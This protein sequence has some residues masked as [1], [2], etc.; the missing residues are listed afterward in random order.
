MSLSRTTLP[1]ISF[2]G[3][4]GGLAPG[5]ESLPAIETRLI[6]VDKGD[7]ALGD[8]SR[9]YPYHTVA[10][11]L[12]AAAALGPTAASRAVVFVYPGEYAES[13]LTSVAH[14]SLV[15]VGGR[16]AVR[17]EGSAG[18][19]LT[20][21]HGSFEV[22]NL[23]LAQSVNDNV[24]RI[25]SPTLC[26]FHNCV[27]DFM[28]GSDTRR[29]ASTV[30]G[31]K[32][33]YEDCAWVNAQFD[34]S[35]VFVSALSALDDH[36]FYRC[37]VRGQLNIQG[38]NAVVDGCVI[39]GMV[40]RGGGVASTMLVKDCVITASV[41]WAVFLTSSTAA[42]IVNNRLTAAAGQYDVASAVA[43]AGHVIEGNVMTRG[44]SGYVSHIAPTRNVGAAGMKDW[45]PTVQAALDSCTFDD[46]V[47]RL[48]VDVGLA[49]ALTPPANRVLTIDGVG[50]HRIT[51][52]AATVLTLTLAGQKVT[53]RDIEVRGQLLINTA[54][55]GCT[56]T[57]EDSWVLGRITINNGL[58]DTV[59]RIVRSEVYGGDGL[60]RALEQIPTA[61]FTYI[62]WSRLKGQ[63]DAAGYAILWNTLTNN[64]VYAKYSK[65]YHGLGA[66][67]DPMGRTGAQTPTWHSHHDQFNS[68][69]GSGWLTNL[70]PPGQTMDSVDPN[71]D[72]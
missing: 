18:V 2:G 48:L 20:V 43:T 19:V 4:G 29:I 67:N 62:E 15:G 40:S 58:A 10:A 21:T 52:A 42:T 17:I 9:Q 41:Y 6:F 71:A 37:T 33:Q 7:N 45:Y 55:A 30:A 72:Y 60:L 22:W 69:P 49:A 44:I 27:F 23:T 31:G 38:G 3:A 25:A 12:A 36:R 34:F 11:G 61:P 59:L 53:L 24:V 35:Q 47:V 54:S 51:W 5:V 65:F 57:I 32:S 64:N 13:G 46:I 56:L 63:A 28:G 16:D 70:I 68:I 66:A 8:G 39:T 50:R 14:T 26:E 1:P